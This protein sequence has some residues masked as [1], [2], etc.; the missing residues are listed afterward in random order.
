MKREFKEEKIDK[1]RRK[2]LKIGIWTIPVIIA[3]TQRKL[4]AGTPAPFGGK[5]K[6]DFF[7]ENEEGEDK[8]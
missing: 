4:W 8:F 5:G 1:I 6:K 2:L 7:E 3:F